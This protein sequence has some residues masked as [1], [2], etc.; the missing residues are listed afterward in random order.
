VAREFWDPTKD[1]QEIEFLL[2]DG[3]KQMWN[4]HFIEQV[5]STPDG[6]TKIRKDPVGKWWF[7]HP[8][9]RT[10]RTVVF[11]PNRNFDGV[12]NLWRGFACDAIPGDCQ[13]FLDHLRNVLCKGNDDYYDYLIRWMA[14]AV[15]NPHLPGQVAVVLKGDQGTGKGTFARIFGHLFGAH[16]KYVSD[17]RHVIGTFNYMLNDAVLVFAD[18]CFVSGSKQHESALKALITEN[19]LRVEQKGVDS[20]DA[21][22]CVHLI[23]ATNKEWAIG[24]ELSDRR[25]FVLDV[26]RARRVDIE[27]FARMQ[28]Q[29]EN[30]GYQ[31]LLHMLMTLDLSD[32]DVRLCPKTEELRNQQDYSLDSMQGFVLELLTE[33][34]LMPGHGSW[35]Q[36]VM[37]NELTDSFKNT[38]G[39]DSRGNLKMGLGKFLRKI[40]AE[41]R[42]RYGAQWAWETATGSK[43]VERNPWVW[44]FPPLEECRRLWKDN[45]GE[46]DWP[47]VADDPHDDY[48]N[49]AF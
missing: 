48:E 15:Q 33:G 24:A 35:R 11:C 4:N 30:G 21:R 2:P 8:N 43:K 22:N 7:A 25:F 9:R 10:Y 40:G 5:V 1:R 31:A 20:V 44:S 49:E 38:Y 26:D 13:M 41:S 47:E 46:R 6:G 42:R 17:P 36:E 23:M 29:M 32:F 27:Y 16:Y 45:F 14:N 12:M 28:E 18:E 39:W 19:T 3:F 37:K 34:R